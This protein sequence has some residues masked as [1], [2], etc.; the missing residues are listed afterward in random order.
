MKNLP[1]Y[2]VFLNEGKMSLNPMKA[3]TKEHTWIYQRDRYGKKTAIAIY[4]E[5]KDL[6][7]ESF[8]ANRSLLLEPNSVAI[9]T[10]DLKT[11]FDE[12]LSKYPNIIQYD[13]GDGTKIDKNIIN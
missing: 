2:E 3:S 5:L 12:V 11:A 1:T 10:K 8:I 4:N 6:G 7:I 9:P 13:Y